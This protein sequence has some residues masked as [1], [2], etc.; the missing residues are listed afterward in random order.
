MKLFRYLYNLVYNTYQ[1]LKIL[2]KNRVVHWNLLTSDATNCHIDKGTR[3]YPRYSLSNV[4]ISKGTYIAFNANISHAFIGKF[5]SIGPNFLCGWGVH[6]T[7][8]ISTSPMFYS[9][10]RQSG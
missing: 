1:L 10:K 4:T 2:S 8:G 7:N 3:L 6:P 5:C 9:T